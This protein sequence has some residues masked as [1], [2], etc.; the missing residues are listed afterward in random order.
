MIA[1]RWLLAAGLAIA[2]M[3][4]GILAAA[5][6]RDD[7]RLGNP[8]VPSAAASASASAGGSNDFVEHF[9]T[10]DKTV[11]GC[12]YTCP[13]IEGEKAR[14]SVKP[15]IPANNVGSWT[16]TRYLPARFTGGRFT[17]R[18]S[19]TARPAQKVWWGVALWDSGP[20]ADG[21][22]FNEINFGVMTDQNFTN[23]ELA[24]ESAKRGNFTSIK[25]DAG[26]ELYDEG[27]HTATIE[28]GPAQV[29]L[30]LDGDLLKIITDQAVIPTDPMDLIIGP[31]LISGSEPLTQSF[32]ESVDWIEISAPRDQIGG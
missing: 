30:F 23:T 22:Q 19:L 24:F 32:T 11:W 5:G 1:R 10:L 3:V 31:R 21:S 4:A 18:F 12:E 9:T 6:T 29:K 26:R 13:S 16:K 17:M 27:W 2:L 8:P 14:F 28:Y 25:V 7:Q 15:G 20:Q